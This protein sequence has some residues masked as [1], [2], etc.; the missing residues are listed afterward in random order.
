VSKIKAV[1]FDVGGVLTHP[2]RPVFV[3]RAMEAGLDPHSVAGVFGSF[4]SAEDAEE[5]AHKLERGEI[6]VEEF[7]DTLG[8]AGPAARHL[9]HHES[10]YFVPEGF[11]PHEGMHAFV[12]EVKAHGYKTALITNSVVEWK[13]WWDR[14]IPEPETFDA[15]VHSCE[16]GLRKPGLGIFRLT[17]EL[18]GVEPD[19][20]LFLDDFPAMAAAGREAGMVV[21]DVH[22]HDQAI[23][24]ARALLG[25]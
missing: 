20:I 2:I 5:P 8:D 19:E 17:A 13:P 9:M 14:V 1:C 12:R 21:I 23:A 22:D 18:L 3:A 7:I 4:S 24:E 15:I 16:V 6:T 11:T 25:F 10:P